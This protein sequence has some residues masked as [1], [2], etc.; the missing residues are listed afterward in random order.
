MVEVAHPGW[1]AFEAQRSEYDL[2]RD[3]TEVAAKE[4]SAFVDTHETVRV[5]LYKETKARGVE[6]DRDFRVWRDRRGIIRYAR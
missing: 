1:Q 3:Q 2:L 6:R 5:V 4:A